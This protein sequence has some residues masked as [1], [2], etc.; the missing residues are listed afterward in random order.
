[1]NSK[2]RFGSAGGL[3]R[4]DKLK[5]WIRKGKVNIKNYK[6]GICEEVKGQ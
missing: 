1:M 4:F 5:S 6:G 2:E 3:R